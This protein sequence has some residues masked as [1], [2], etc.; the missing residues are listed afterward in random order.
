MCPEHV[1]FDWRAW[2]AKVECDGGGGR[3]LYPTNQLAFLEDA[4][5][6][7]WGELPLHP[8]SPDPRCRKPDP[9]RIPISRRFLYTQLYRVLS[10]SNYYFSV[11]SASG[12]EMAPDRK[13]M[14]LFNS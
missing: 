6:G 14:F 13:F 10:N 9:R 1:R 7:W 2:I 3:E 12:A 11:V 8:L 5:V 4:L